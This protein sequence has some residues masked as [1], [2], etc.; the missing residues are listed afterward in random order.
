MQLMNKYNLPQ[1][2]VNAVLH[3]EKN[4]QKKRGEKTRMSITQ[5]I[6]PPLYIRLQD[7]HWD[8]LE[9]DISERIWI[10]IGNLMHKDLENY[11]DKNSLTEER[12]FLEVNGWTI[13]GQADIYEA[14]A[15]LSDYKVTSVYAVKD[16]VKPE[17]EAQLNCLAYL[18][19]QAGFKV[20]KLKLVAILRDWS[21]NRVDSNSDYPP[22]PVKVMEVKKWGKDKILSYI[23]ERVKTH[24]DASTMP[25]K[26]IPVCTAEERWQT[27]TVYALMKKGRKS[28]IKLYDT[29]KEADKAEEEY[30]GAVGETYVEVREGKSI[31]CEEY[32]SVAD[33][34]PFYK[35]EVAE[36]A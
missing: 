15:T 9:E 29:K 34:C 28:A 36:N 6:A 16:G 27:D 20:G 14:D 5:L 32:C 31:R 8:K 25:I 17:Y 22:I 33:Y 4:Y 3:F 19:E 30:A 18:Y 13:S 2:I 12:L 11:A 1:P 21:K 24:Q 23:N 35:K 7:E 10:L 26:S